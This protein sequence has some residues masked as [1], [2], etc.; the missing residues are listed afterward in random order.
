MTNQEVI[1]ICSNF[2]DPVEACRKIANESY[3]KWIKKER[4]TDDITMICIFVDDL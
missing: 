2:T 4:R 3:E 1:D